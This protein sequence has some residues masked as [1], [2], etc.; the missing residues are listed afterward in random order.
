MNAK[1]VSPNTFEGSFSRDL[2]I[3]KLWALDELSKVENNFQT[4]YVLG[5]WYGNM[6]FIIDK[7]QDINFEKLFNIDIDQDVLNNSKEIYN[8]AEIKNVKFL[9]IDANDLKYRNAKDLNLVINTSTNNIKNNQ[10]FKNI[11]KGSVVLLQGRNNDPGAVNKF[12]SLKEFKDTF[13]LKKV[14]YVGQITVTTS[15]DEDYDSY[16]I[17]GIK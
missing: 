4:I 9:N 5:S 14:L 3:R 7:T 8:K 6:G 11:P 2:I 10:W 1:K 16:M 12:T 17:I 13:L 15:E